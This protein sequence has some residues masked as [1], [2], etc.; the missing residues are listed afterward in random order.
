MTPE[1]QLVTALPTWMTAA[2]QGQPVMRSGEY[3]LSP[4]LQKRPAIMTTQSINL[5]M[6]GGGG[7]GA[8]GEAQAVVIAL[9]VNGQPGYYVSL[10]QSGPQLL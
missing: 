6:A 1:E 7:G 3:A 10:A 4:I 9:A 8:G 2:P 5:G